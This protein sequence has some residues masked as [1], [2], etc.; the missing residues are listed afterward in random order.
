VRLITYRAYVLS[1]II[2]LLSKLPGSP[3]NVS[4]D[5]GKS[6]IPHESY[7]NKLS[8]GSHGWICSQTADHASIEVD[9][10]VGSTQGIM[11]GAI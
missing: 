7:L 3:Q 4:K 5:Y 6:N 9:G 2:I 11:L 1:D 8:D 10:G